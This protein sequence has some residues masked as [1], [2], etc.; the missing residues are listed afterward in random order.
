MRRP[1]RVQ[2]EV[3]EGPLDLLLHL[4]KKNEL[5][6]AD[7]PTAK[8]TEQ[9]VEYLE[10][11]ES[12]SLDVAGEY[13]VMAATLLLIKSRTLL[14]SDEGEAPEED[15]PRIDLV[16]QLQEYQRYREAALTLAERPMLQRDVFARAPLNLVD[17]DDPAT[18]PRDDGPPN[19]RVSMWQLL[20]A[21][22]GVLSRLEPEP[23]HEVAVEKISL[24][25]RTRFLLT[26]LQSQPK[27]RFDS[28]FDADR[29]RL[30]VIVT[31][32]ALLELM[33]MGAAAAVQEEALG[34][35]VIELKV[36]DVAQLELDGLE[37][38]ESNALGAA[39]EGVDEEVGADGNV[40]RG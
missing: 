23:V 30:Q 29:T 8:I 22:R 33:K 25:D 15:D 24:R 14:P 39:A 11:M 37:E 31:F 20:D 7:V 10:M 16:R 9:Y 18:K 3:F 19:V 17:P 27:L 21:M 40:A 12:L 6:L 28:L 32:L 35:I 38:Y 4:V 13:L 34:P 36:E 2:L 5:Q 26:R 1:Y